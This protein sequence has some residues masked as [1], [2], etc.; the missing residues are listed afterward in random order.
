[1]REQSASRG[2][3][4][5]IRQPVRRIEHRIAGATL[6]VVT[7]CVLGALSAAL[8]VSFGARTQTGV[9][10]ALPV[11]ATSPVPVGL[12]DAASIDPTPPPDTGPSPSAASDPTSAPS[13]APAADVDV[14]WAT[15]TNG[16]RVL[17]LTIRVPSAPGRYPVV[18]FAHGFGASAATYARLEEQVASAGF[19]VVAP[20]FPHS[21]STAP[22]EL[23]R[24]D[25]VNQAGDVSAVITVLSD[26]ATTPDALRD[27]ILVGPVGVVG[28]SDGGI[29]A[30][31]VA[32]NSSVADPRIGAAVVLSGA[33][34]MYPGSWFTGQSPPLLAVHGDA[35][36]VN[37]WWSSEQLFDWAT[38]PRALVTVRGGSHAGP[39]TYS[40]VEPAVGA[41]A[42]DFLRAYLD[43][44][45]EALVRMTTDA[46]ADGLTLT[47]AR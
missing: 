2:S 45:S 7:L 21:S 46:A 8:P 39:F 43:G 17:P 36:E 20:E 16:A 14:L 23:D 10:H 32:Y 35:D 13:P 31:A 5:P 24:A 28:H 29:T 33:A 42:G 47:N 37:P 12:G 40:D 41:L 6:A 26:P 15:V 38:G 44:D 18:V 22:N 25:V 1:M 30:A 19:V 4:L 34:V 27:R 11:P 9:A 3:L